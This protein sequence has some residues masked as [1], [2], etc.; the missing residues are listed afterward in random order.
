MRPRGIPAEIFVAAVTY[1][2]RFNEAAGDT[3]GNRRPDW[4]VASASGKAASM[5]PRGIPAE[6][7]SRHQAVEQN[8]SSFNEAAGDTRGNPRVLG[9]ESL[10]DFASMRPRGIPAE[11]SLSHPIVAAAVRCAASMRPRGIPAEIS[12]RGSMTRTLTC[13]FNEA[14]GDTRG[15]P[16]IRSFIHITSFSF[17]E[18]AGDTRGNPISTV[19]SVSMSMR[20][21]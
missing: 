14:A 4:N 1:R 8:R 9:G 19:E 12:G 3:R 13:C 10:C 15:N 18:A 21:Q 5:R 7:I 11:I 20:L 2:S 6:I 16:S 17:N